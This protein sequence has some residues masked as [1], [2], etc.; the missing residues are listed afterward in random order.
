MRGLGSARDHRLNLRPASVHED[1]RAMNHSSPPPVVHLCSVFR[2]AYAVFLCCHQ[3]LTLTGLKVELFGRGT[4]GG[5]Q[6]GH[7]LSASRHQ[8]LNNGLYSST[9]IVQKSVLLHN[10]STWLFLLII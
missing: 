6:R 7:Q 3:S 1:P 5:V 4:A 2:A 9:F 8:V 10:N